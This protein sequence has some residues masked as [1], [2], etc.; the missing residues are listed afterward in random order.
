M[1]VQGLIIACQ[2]PPAAP[3]ILASFEIP[4]PT[5]TPDKSASMAETP[6]TISGTSWRNQ[7]ANRG[8]AVW[9]MIATRRF[10][11]LDTVISDNKQRN[12]T[13]VDIDLVAYS[14]ALSRAGHILIRVETSCADGNCQYCG[15]STCTGTCSSTG[16]GFV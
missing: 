6:C 15:S 4:N 16:G 13:V 10:G 5:L 2:S 14:R 12:Q 1:Y 8:R 9:T 7:N 11:P 3:T